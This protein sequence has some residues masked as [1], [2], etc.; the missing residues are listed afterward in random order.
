ML[1]AFYRL[2][3]TAH[4]YNLSQ[5][6]GFPTLRSYRLLLHKHV[7]QGPGR[8]ILEI[9]C[10]LGWAR[11]LF[12]GE[13]TGIDVNPDYIREAS[14]K[15]SGT[16]LVM[17]AAQ[18]PFAPDS[19]DDAVSIATGHHLSDEQLAA[20]VRKA[21]EVASSLHIVDAILP[22]SSRAWFKNIL[23]RMD[24][25]RHQRTADQLRALVSRNAHI[26]LSEVL[27][28]PLHDVCYVRASRSAHGDDRK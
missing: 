25:G 8:R 1:K 17:D 10:G 12:A 7:P 24:R 5:V 3:D 15:L 18:M 21:T 27:E 26:Q 2:L 4:G 28:G 9:G 16:F 6:L 22:V 23:F 20:M 19:F 13:Y 14:S 11:T